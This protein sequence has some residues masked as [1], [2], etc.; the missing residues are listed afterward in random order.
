[1]DC[2]K[3]KK[4]MQEGMLQSPSMIMWVKEK[5][6]NKLVFR[7][8]QGEILLAPLTNIGLEERL[9]GVTVEAFHCPDCKRVIV[10]Y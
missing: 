6:R 5:Q 7:P 4:G 2:P 8:K 10:D 3:C 1:M 9:W